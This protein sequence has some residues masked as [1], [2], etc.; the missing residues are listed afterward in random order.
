MSTARS[1][2]LR[3][4]P[5]SLAL[6]RGIHF[7]FSY[8]PSIRD[9]TSRR[10]LFSN[11]LSMLRLSRGRNLILSSGAAKEMELRAPWDVINLGVLCGIEPPLSKA[12]VSAH[13]RAVL[14]HAEARKTMKCVL[15][16]I[17][18]DATEPASAAS[19]SGASAGG[20][21][22]KPKMTDE[23]TKHKD[24]RAKLNNNNK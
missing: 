7:E 14:L 11:L 12:S 17:K 1:F 8:S 13:A 18:L 4:V 20:V 5:F 6:E 3:L 23:E 21:H 15:R 16:E 22:P 9:A 2:S 10:Y 19:A 24:K